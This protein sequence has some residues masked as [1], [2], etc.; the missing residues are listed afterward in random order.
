MGGNAL[1]RRHQLFQQR[2]AKQNQLR[3]RPQ[4]TQGD[5]QARPVFGHQRV[6]QGVGRLQKGGVFVKH[7][8]AVARRTA[9]AVDAAARNLLGLQH[10]EPGFGVGKMQPAQAIKKVVQAFARGHLA[11]AVDESLIGLARRQRLL[12]HKAHRAGRTG[13]VGGRAVDALRAMVIQRLRA[14]GSHQRLCGQ[15]LPLGAPGRQPGR[16]PVDSV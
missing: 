2:V 14:V 9:H 6:P 15:P 16:G 1:A 7:G 12:G 5:K 4:R 10:V 11:R 3:L 8:N 13:K